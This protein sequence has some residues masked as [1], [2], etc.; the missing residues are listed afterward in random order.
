MRF[1]KIRWSSWWWLRELCEVSRYLLCRGLRHYCP[2][3]NVPY[4]F[5]NKCL[6]YSYYMAGYLLDRPCV[7]VC[8]CVWVC[9]CSDPSESKGGFISGPDM[10]INVHRSSR[11]LY[12]MS[13]NNAYSQLPISEDSQPWI[14]NTVFDSRLVEPSD[15][16]PRDM[17][18]SLYN[19]AIKKEWDLFSD[20]LWGHYASWNKLDREKQMPYD[21]TYVWNLKKNQKQKQKPSSENRLVGSRSG[22][23]EG[24]KGIHF[25]L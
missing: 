14:K 4:I 21:L 6:Y 15:A 24:S 22:V 23:G 13:Q 20:G 25:Q 18:G 5:F 19:A 1:R 12:K 7:C 10:D 2:M 3:Y 17:K 16:K 9:V 8:V 11:F